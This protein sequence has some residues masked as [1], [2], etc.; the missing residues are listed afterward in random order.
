[1]SS[2]TNNHDYL[3]H[4]SLDDRPFMHRDTNR[5][6]SGS[7]QQNALVRIEQFLESGLP[8]AILQSDTGC[9]MTQLLQYL[10]MHSGLGDIA[11]EMVLAPRIP[12]ANETTRMVWLVDDTNVEELE[13]V[14]WSDPNASILVGA[15]AE[16]TTRKLVRR[17][18]RFPTVI[19]LKRMSGPDAH[20]YV[21]YSIRMAGGRKPI[22]TPSAV[23]TLFELSGG[24]IRDFALMAEHSL[25]E[26]W[27]LGEEEIGTRLIEQIVIDT[28]CAA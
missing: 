18:G 25:R 17:L 20:A 14:P 21:N 13:R 3:K 9:G 11:V 28:K 22:F 5:F 6:F 12:V 8:A 24:R 26:S 2:L 19:E 23:S 27:G 4:W 1:M 10:S 16:S 15:V 7:A